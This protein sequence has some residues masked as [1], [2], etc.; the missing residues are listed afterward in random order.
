MADTMMAN[1]LYSLHGY[2]SFLN[3]S[4]YDRLYTNFLTFT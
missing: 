1:G 4:L 2:P 3:G